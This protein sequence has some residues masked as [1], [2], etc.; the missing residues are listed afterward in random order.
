MASLLALAVC[1]MLAL[2]AGQYIRPVLDFIGEL[3]EIGGI[4]GEMVGVLMKIDWEIS[5]DA[6]ALFSDCFT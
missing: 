6:D 3:E 5:F 1:V 2:T 4:D